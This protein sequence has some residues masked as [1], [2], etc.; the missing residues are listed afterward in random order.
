MCLGWNM[1]ELL[2]QRLKNKKGEPEVYLYDEF[3]KEFRNQVFYILSDVLDPYTDFDDDLWDYVHDKFFR[4]KGLKRSGRHYTSSSGYGKDNIETYIDEAS[5]T[6]FLDFVDYVFYLFD[7]GLRDLYPKYKSDYDP[8]DAVTKAIKEL[9]F[10][11]K[12]HQ[13]G[14]EFVN[15]E[16]IRIDT[17]I[18]HKEII[19]PALKLLYEEGFSG[20]E[21]E[22]RRAFEKRR[23][24]DNKNAIL[25]AG[26]AFESTMK[27]ICDKKGYPYDKAKDT[28]Q[29][30]IN[31]LESNHFYPPYMTAHLTNLRTTLETGLP[32]IRNKTSGHGQGSTVVTISEEFAEYALNLA[33]ANIVL[34]VKIYKNTK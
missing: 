24:S 12:Q 1:F 31:I 11:F 18:I 14:Y 20:A 33:A 9:N 2:S 16:I 26:K 4:E 3:P 23:N 28:A 25:E 5:H 34:L 8:D 21:E 13:L 32:V 17:T 30:L 7:I 22:I 15:G 10:R 27:T 19:K 29:K 6:D